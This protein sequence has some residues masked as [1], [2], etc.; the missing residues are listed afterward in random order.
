MRYWENVLWLAMRSCK[1]FAG[2]C[3]SDEAA[4]MAYI[5]GRS[6]PCQGAGPCPDRE[7]VWRDLDGGEGDQAAALA[8]GRL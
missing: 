2:E 1:R 8:T 3:E 4:G 5:R 6:M 7:V